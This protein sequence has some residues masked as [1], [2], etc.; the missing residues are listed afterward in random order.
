MCEFKEWFLEISNSFS[1]RFCLF[2]CCVY[3]QIWTVVCVLQI[4]FNF[5]SICQLQ[6]LITALSSNTVHSI[7]NWMLPLWFIKGCAAGY[8]LLLNRR[9][10][11]ITFFV[12]EKRTF[13]LRPASGKIYKCW[14]IWLSLSPHINQISSKRASVRTPVSLLHTPIGFLCVWF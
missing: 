3:K 14:K 9:T 2:S 4:H 5:T 6:P 1:F 8:L 11:A 12:M 13:A 10:L 7:Y